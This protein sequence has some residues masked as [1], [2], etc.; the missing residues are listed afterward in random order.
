MSFPVEWGSETRPKG[1]AFSGLGVFASHLNGLLGRLCFVAGV[2]LFEFVMRLGLLHQ[3]G[4]AALLIVFGAAVV[5][6]RLAH[7]FLK[8]QTEVL[9]FSLPLFFAHLVCLALYFAGFYSGSIYALTHG[10]TIALQ[11]AHY[12][13]LTAPVVFLALASVP[14]SVCIPTLRATT[15]AWICSLLAAGILALLRSVMGA[16]LGLLRTITI[17]AVGLVLHS[18]LPGV[19]VDGRACVINAPNFSVSVGMGCSGWEG[20]GLVLVFGGCWL[21]YF[22]SEIRLFRASLLVLVA[23]VCAGLLNVVRICALMLIGNFISSD[24]AV[25][26]FHSTAGWILFL[27]VALALAASCQNLSWVRKPTIAAHADL[28]PASRH[29]DAGS[30]ALQARFVPRATESPLAP[31]YLLPFLFVLGSAFISR[32]A[33]GLFDWLYPLRFFAGAFAIWYFR[34]ELKR[35]KWRFGWGAAFA[36]I[37]VFLIW[38]APAA[39]SHTHT[40]SPLGQALGTLPISLR[41]GWIFFRVLTAVTVVPIAEE[42]AFRG[43]LARR[44]VCREFDFVSFT[45]LTIPAVLFS[46]L[47]FG[48][49]HGSRWIAGTLAGLAFATLLRKSGRMGD[50]VAAHAVSNLLLAVWVLIMGDWAQW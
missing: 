3:R 16:P 21:F 10:G 41:I 4:H 35:L 24:V 26:G 20:V 40:S 17:D 19:T 28:P 15:P 12:A 38:I 33:S 11:A 23:L 49:M 48:L 43:Y 7:P 9:P 39:W 25:N 44:I 18:I 34:A 8:S 50:A 29:L 47:A 36:G 37:S 14:F 13:S 22:R 27:G 32:A 2:L 46:S 5:Y 45:S 1:G 30:P 31:A 6:L 42:L